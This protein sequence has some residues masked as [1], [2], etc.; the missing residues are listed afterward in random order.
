MTQER[1]QEIRDRDSRKF[2][3][4]QYHN[5]IMCQR[6]RKELLDYVEEL[7]SKIFSLFTD[8]DLTEFS[9]DDVT[10]DYLLE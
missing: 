2:G 5:L 9:D 1:L 8:G 7:E 4:W 3:H 6:D 10:Q